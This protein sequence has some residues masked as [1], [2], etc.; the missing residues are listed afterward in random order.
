LAHGDLGGA[1][2]DGADVAAGAAVGLVL[3]MLAVQRY[4]PS[5][6]MVM[7]ALE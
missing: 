7:P 5:S 2:G 6:G 3:P 4:R 1:V